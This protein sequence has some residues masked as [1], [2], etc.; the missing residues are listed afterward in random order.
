MRIGPL[1]ATLLLLAAAPAHADAIPSDDDCPPLQSWQ[2]GHDGECGC[3]VDPAR[4]ADPTSIWLAP[5]ALLAIRR[6]ERHRARAR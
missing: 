2:G 1:I 6:G 3:A 5:L 4:S